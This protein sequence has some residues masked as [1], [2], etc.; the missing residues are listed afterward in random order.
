MHLHYQL[1]MAEMR[2]E[3]AERGHM[4]MATE[5]HVEGSDKRS[6]Y[7]SKTVVDPAEAGRL[8]LNSS[9]ES[10][11]RI[12][13]LAGKY[14]HL[15]HRTTLDQRRNEIPVVLRDAAT[16]TEGFRHE[17][18]HSR[19][20]RHAKTSMAGLSARSTSWDQR[21]EARLFD[22]LESFVNKPVAF[23]I[24]AAVGTLNPV[25]FRFTISSGKGDLG[26]FASQTLPFPRVSIGMA[27]AS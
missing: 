24:Q 1:G 27:G 8:L 20:D 12:R 18:E 6:I 26:A 10:A 2:D 19:L 17:R 21:R 7:R 9:R 13:C 15:R 22:T 16:P 14:R 5:D 23:A 11:Y 4:K 3:G 25:L